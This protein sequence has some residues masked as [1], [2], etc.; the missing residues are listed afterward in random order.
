MFKLKS[1]LLLPLAFFFLLLASISLITTQPQLAHA[2]PG[3]DTAIIDTD[4]EFSN[5]E[6]ATESADA[7]QAGQLASPSAEVVQ[8][9]QEIRDRDITEPSGQQ[10]GKLATFLDANPPGPL[11]WNNF[12]QHAIRYAVSE[13]VQANI[14]VLVLLFPLIVSMI[15]ASRH[16]IG[17]RGF[18]IYIPAVLSVALV[19]TGLLAGLILFL[20]IIGTSLF[21]KRLLRLTKLPYL[22]RTALMLWLVS[23]AILG[24]ILLAPVLDLVALMGLS[25]FPI[26]ILVLLAE[27]FLDAQARTKQKE[28]FMLTLETLGLAIAGGF[29]L[30]WEPMQFLAL[31][32]PELLLIVSGII[33]LLIGKFVG[34]RLSER[35]RFRSLIEEEE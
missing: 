35:M 12:L 21:A 3:L 31:S 24:I 8:R 17:L 22:P 11:S 27:N 26:L 6:E 20:A 1:R 33:N 28:A 19:S 32:E 9:L 13:G 18:G 15:A 14:I 23:I 29:F 5:P 25:I 16:I 34:L 10:K 30:K 7:T 4:I 2:Q